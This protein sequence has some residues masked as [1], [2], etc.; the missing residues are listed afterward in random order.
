MTE[1]PVRNLRLEIENINTEGNVERD[2]VSLMLG[3]TLDITVKFEVP[4]YGAKM[5]IEK[6]VKITVV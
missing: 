4:L 1:A 6:K 5:L 2:Q 3:D